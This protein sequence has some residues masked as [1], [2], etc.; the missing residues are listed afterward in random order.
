[1]HLNIHLLPG[2]KKGWGVESGIHPLI[3]CEFETNLSD[4]DPTC[5]VIT[6]PDPTFKVT[7]DPDPKRIRIKKDPGQEADQVRMRHYFLGFY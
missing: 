2:E 3:C 5:Q 7:S 6:D 1:M 4:P